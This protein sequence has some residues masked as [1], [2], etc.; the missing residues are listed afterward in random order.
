MTD[1]ISIYL[2]RHGE[3]SASWGEDRDPGLSGLGREQA[4][5]AA[6]KL[7]PMGPMALVTSPMRRAQETAAAFSTV[8]G[9]TPAI[10]P[11]V[12]ELPSPTNDLEERREWLMDVMPGSW[13]API[14]Q[15]AGDIDLNQWRADLIDAVSSLTR[16]TVITSHFIAI[17]VVVG[18]ILGD[19]RVVCFRPDNCSVTEIITKNGA[20]EIASLGHEAE[21]D[22]G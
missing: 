22:V 10:E 19:D 16:P 3:A 1:R 11:R 17:N 9:I 7:A 20:M 13:S 12:T 21:T 14:A 15:Q 6:E 4:R 8:W 2:V 5:L 18:H